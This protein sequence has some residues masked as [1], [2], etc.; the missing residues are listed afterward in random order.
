MHG[1]VEGCEDITHVVMAL[2]DNLMVGEFKLVRDK[3][4]R[5]LTTGV[6]AGAKKAVYYLRLP[7]VSKLHALMSV[8]FSKKELVIML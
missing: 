6:N 3:N 1:H 4:L 8:H 2:E 7:W 5:E